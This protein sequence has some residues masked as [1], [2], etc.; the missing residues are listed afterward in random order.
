M[1]LNNK[2]TKFCKHCGKQILK[3]AVICVNCGLQVEELKNERIVINNSYAD[4]AMYRNANKGM[5]RKKDK[6]IALAL[7]IFL[8]CIG[9][10]KFYE[11][12]NGL[13]V[14]YLLTGGLFGIGVL[15]DIFTLLFKENPYYI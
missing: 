13:G 2:D 12:K 5:Y 7:C 11:C 8:G 15:I 9:A 6:W 14:L 4:K 10:H 3:E 1:T